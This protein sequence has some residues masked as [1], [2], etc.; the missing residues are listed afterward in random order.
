MPR[1]D[2][3]Q[4]AVERVDGQPNASTQHQ[5]PGQMPR[6]CEIRG[7]ERAGDND[8]RERGHDRQEER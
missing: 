2:T 1:P 6:A 8:R 3:L 4:D 7:K 5:P